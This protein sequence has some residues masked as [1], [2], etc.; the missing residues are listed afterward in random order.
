AGLAAARAIAMITYRS[1]AEFEQRF[2]RRQPRG[3]ERFDVDGYLRHQGEQLV[4]RFDERSY[5]TL[6]VAMDRHDLSVLEAAA[7]ETAERVD[8]V[9]GVGIDSDILYPAAAVRDW[10][11][12]YRAAGAPAAYREITSIYGHDAFLIELHQ[13][14]AALTAG[15]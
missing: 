8:R 15:I 5:L 10:V 9:V 7:A 13:V 1:E 2:G 12:R 6:M 4:A 11:D 14:G 3:P